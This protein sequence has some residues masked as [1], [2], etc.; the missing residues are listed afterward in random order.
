MT[1]YVDELRRWPTS[2]MTPVC[3]RDGSCHLT[4]DTEAELHAFARSIGLRRSW[5]QDHPIHPHYDLTKRKRELAVE[6]GAVF[7][8]AREQAEERLKLIREAKRIIRRRM[9]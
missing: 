9:R 5:F 3:F 4:A 7:K 1:V 2:G 6:K 8:S